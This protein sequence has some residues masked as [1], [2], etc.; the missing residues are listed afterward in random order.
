MSEEMIRRTTELMREQT[1]SYH[2][3]TSNCEQLIVALARGN[4][5]QLENLTRTGERE[6]LTIR[7]RLLQITST[8]TTFAQARTSAP[9]R[10]PISP[11]TRRNFEVA[12]QALIQAA[13]AFQLV[14]QRSASLAAN[15][16]VFAHACLEACGGLATRYTSSYGKRR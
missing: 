14:R 16:T 1:H 9:T 2:R 13:Q 11:E 7:S 12:S 4:P 15:G 8:L 6:L 10:A 3:L 5:E